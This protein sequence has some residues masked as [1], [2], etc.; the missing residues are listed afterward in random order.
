MQSGSH[1]N[2]AK[3]RHLCHVQQSLIFSHKSQDLMHVVCPFAVTVP[4]S[5]WDSSFYARIKALLK[6]FASL[7]MGEFCVTSGRE[8]LVLR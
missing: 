2:M 6:S 3:E 7:L 5:W 4:A 8:W 1:G